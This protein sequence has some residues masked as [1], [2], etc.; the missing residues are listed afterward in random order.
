MFSIASTSWVHPVSQF[1]FPFAKCHLPLSW[2]CRDTSV[3]LMACNFLSLSYFCLRVYFYPY[4]FLLSSHSLYPFHPP[5]HKKDPTII[6]CRRGFTACSSLRADVIYNAIYTHIYI[7]LVIFLMTSN[8]FLSLEIYTSEFLTLE[9]TL[10]GISG[11]LIVLAVR[12]FS[13]K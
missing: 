7:Q 2:K 4:P 11:T 10:K 5:P 1:K 6:K 13:K 12:L 9:G 8:S 3:P